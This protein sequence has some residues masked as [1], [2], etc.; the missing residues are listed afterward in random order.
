MAALWRHELR[1]A[2]TIRAMA[3][4]AFRLSV[5]QFP[6]F[7]GALAVVLAPGH[8]WPAVLL[9]LA[10][11]VRAGTGRL[12]ET[13]L[14]A[15]TTPLWLAPVRDMMSVAVMAAALLGEEVSWRGQ[16]L[17]T[18]PDR[19]LVIDHDRGQGPPALAHGEG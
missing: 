7:W 16:V 19:A 11:A 8:A 10:V 17:T 9:A 13:A 6:I 3:P 1:W 12:I 4:V 5:V 15:E 18:A 14:G 2:R